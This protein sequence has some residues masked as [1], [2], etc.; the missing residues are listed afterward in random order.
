VAVTL[1][2]DVQVVLQDGALSL[3]SRL[4]EQNSDL[5]WLTHSTATVTPV[6]EPPAPLTPILTEVLDP[7]CVMARLDAIGVVGIGF[8]WRVLEVGRTPERLRVRIAADPDGEMTVNTW[9]SLFDAALS[10]APVLFPGGP[11]LR[12]PGALREVRVH[13]APPAEALVGIEL[14]DVRWSEDQAGDVEVDIVI[15]DRDGTVAARLAGVRFGVVQHAAAPDI[16]EAEAGED[17]W[18]DLP[19]PELARHVEVLVREVIAAEL[20]ADP[21]EL[22]HHRPLTEMGVDSLLG[23]SIRQ[24]LARRFRTAL[25][26]G[27]LWDR[28]NVA[29]LGDH[30]CE[31]VAQERPAA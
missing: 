7:G 26:S 21:D 22:D 1:P 25:P 30:L 15:A 6:S 20:R 24:G 8:P 2:R 12:M 9:G 13:G 4:A 10:A 31:L 5:S 18:R 11:R 16:T 3:S 29:S 23:E 17:S 14:V 19:A 27:L 28:P